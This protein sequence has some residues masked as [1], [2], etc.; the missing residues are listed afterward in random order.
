MKF[1]ILI[2]T[3]LYS[4]EW[5]SFTVHLI[6]GNPSH[7]SYSAQICHN[8]HQND[9]SMESFRT[10]HCVLSLLTKANKS[11]FCSRLICMNGWGGEKEMVD[12]F[13]KYGNLLNGLWQSHWRSLFRCRWLP[14][15]WLPLSLVEPPVRGKRR[16]LPPVSTDWQSITIAVCLYMRLTDW[17]STLPLAHTISPFT[18]YKFSINAAKREQTVS[19]S[20]CSMCVKAQSRTWS[21]LSWCEKENGKF[22]WEKNCVCVSL[23]P[24]SYHSKA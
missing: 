18:L 13:I 5:F 2:K 24:A 3:G 16:K 6:W 14:P 11:H 22:C 4:P 17:L 23:H 9:T 19:R 8:L 7:A 21:W 10:S 1:H 20:D 12:A 15:Y